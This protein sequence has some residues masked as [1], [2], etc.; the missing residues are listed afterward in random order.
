M[1]E[2]SLKDL[3]DIKDRMCAQGLELDVIKHTLSGL[4]DEKK[5]DAGNGESEM[6]LKEINL[7]K[8]DITQMKD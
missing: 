3:S 4:I 7:L 1:L 2:P 5:R 8:L 6:A